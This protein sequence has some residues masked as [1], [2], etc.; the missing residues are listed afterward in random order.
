MSDFTVLFVVMLLLGSGIEIWLAQRQIRHVRAH[1]D[2]VPAAFHERI[3]SAA[4]RRAADYSVARTRL[5][6]GETLYGAVI[7]LGWT[8]GGGLELLDRLWRSAGWGPVATGTGFLIA[9]FTLSAALDLPFTLYRTFGIEQRYGFNRTT[10]ALFLADLLKQFA[11]LLLLG[12]PFAALVLWLM[13][14]AGK[15]WWLDVWVAWMA[16]SLILLWAYP[17]FI[18]PLFNRFAPLEDEALRRRIEQLLTRCGFQS[19]GIFVMDGSR[20][21]AHGNAYFT[22]LGHHKRI[23]FFDTLLK[24]LDGGEVEAVL[25]H[26]LG[27]FRHH[28][29]RKRLMMMGAGS[30]A[31]LALLG[32]LIQAPW[33]YT[34][35]GVA[36]P[37]LHAALALFLLVSPVFT[38]F[39][40]PLMARSMRAHEFEAD[41]FAAAE[42]GAE[43]LVSALV[44]LYRENA[45]TLTPDRLYSAFHDS[46]PPAPVRVAR[47]SAK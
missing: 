32:W 16:L 4:H 46:H 11:L 7:L 12:G 26:E 33:F 21:S 41:A 1:R 45:S 29:V 42:V 3:S 39:V 17:A 35:L 36:T 8:L 20:R 9:L 44:K 23:V 24:Q 2:Q 30:L 14:H 6:I 40:Q 38:F 10:P 37:S 28:H 34:G 18:A 19:E 13:A 27:H 47:L 15:L 31:G 43:T 5:G 25:A 22:G